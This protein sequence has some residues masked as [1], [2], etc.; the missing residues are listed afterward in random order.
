MKTKIYDFSKV[1]FEKMTP[2]EIMELSGLNRSQVT[3]ICQFLGIVKIKSKVKPIIN[4]NEFDGLLGK[5]CDREVAEKI[6]CASKFV[7]KRRKELGIKPFYSKQDFDWDSVQLG[8]SSDEEVAKTLG[9][10]IYMVRVERHRRKILLRDHLLDEGPE[11]DEVI[12][13]SDEPER[14]VENKNEEI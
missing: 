11:Q 2:I 8:I 5:V 1:D 9:C 6:G 14:P 7:S 12:E 3:A 13:T 10:S 4:W